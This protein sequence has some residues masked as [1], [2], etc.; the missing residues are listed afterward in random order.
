MCPTCGS[1]DQCEH[2]DQ[3][4]QSSRA[5]NTTASKSSV[6]DDTCEM[7]TNSLIHPDTEVFNTYDSSAPNSKLLVHYGFMLEANS[8]DMVFFEIA[9]L[10]EWLEGL[11]GTPMEALDDDQG[12]LRGLGASDL[13]FEIEQDENRKSGDNNST[14]FAIN[15]EGVMSKRLF[16]L[17]VLRN[18]WKVQQSGE[19]RWP[20]SDFFG[21]RAPR[22]AVCECLAI[23]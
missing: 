6:E 5:S 12:L 13:F 7:V 1:F 2:D 9:E 19:K 3:D 4:E 11:D 10:G 21:K 17:L 8:N 20:A 18:M 22:A 14:K 16:T 15:A 23:G